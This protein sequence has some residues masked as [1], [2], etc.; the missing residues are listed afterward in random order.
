MDDE[1]SRRVGGGLDIRQFTAKLEEA[2]QI[3]CREMYRI[4][5]TSTP[6]AMGR[7]VPWWTD[8]LQVTRKRTN[9][10][11]RRYQRTTTKL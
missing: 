8:E 6:K 4:K 5:E 10:L 2:I 11:R 3:T 7:T 9:T 1:L